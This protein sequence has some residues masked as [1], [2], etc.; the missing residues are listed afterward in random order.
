PQVHTLSIGAARPTDFDRHLE[1]LP[2]LEKAGELL[3]PIVDRLQRTMREAVAGRL[4]DPFALDLPR[5]QDTPGEM[6]LPVI[7]WLRSLALAYDMREYGQMRYNLLG[8]GGHWFPGKNAEKAEELAAEL[9]PIAARAGLN[10]DLVPLL[11]EAH[12]L[13]GKEPVK[14]LSQS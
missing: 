4:A 14:R 6:N 9:A 10:G 11:R 13:L 8:N 12:E 3:P 1:T 2:L 5:W 7:L